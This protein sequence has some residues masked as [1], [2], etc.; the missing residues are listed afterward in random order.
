[1][2]FKVENYVINVVK[3]TYT[4]RFI[5]IQNNLHY[6]GFIPFEKFK[7]DNIHKYIEY[8][9]DKEDCIKI[10]KKENHYILK[11][12]KPFC[13]NIFRHEIYLKQLKL[14]DLKY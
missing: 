9:A 8:Y 6:T 10:D 12:P 14:I 11:L 5:L 7:V 3:K 2:I 1:M 13:S 4:Y